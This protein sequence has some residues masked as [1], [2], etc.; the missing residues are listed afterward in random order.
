MTPRALFPIII[1]LLFVVAGSGRAENLSLEI[2]GGSALNFPTSLT[3]HQSGYPDLQFNAN[4]DTKPLGPYTAYYSWRVGLW[5]K[6]Q[7]WEI[8]Q[9]HHRI[10]LTNSPPEVQFFAIHF[11]Y[12]Y[13]FFG[14]AWR[15][16]GL[17]YHLG[18]GPVITN[19]EN[20]VRGQKLYTAGTGL[21]DQGYDF[22]GIG[23]EA[24]LSK[25]IYLNPN[26]FAALEVAFIAG[27]AWWVPVA[28]G[29]A[30]VPNMAVHGHIGMGY[31]F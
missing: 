31:C 13:F 3:I 20:T 24:S 18:I 7:A 9:V 14:H 30:D 4:Y 23:A 10:F 19:P 26:L 22:S 6:D 16:G 8:Q 17:I 1:F 5:N 21:F 2:M 15:K 12:N 29:Y 11:G 28:D 27:W 25:N